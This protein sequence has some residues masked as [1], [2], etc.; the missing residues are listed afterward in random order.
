MDLLG[1]CCLWVFFVPERNLCMIYGLVSRNSV[2]LSLQQQWDRFVSIKRYLWLGNQT[3]EKVTSYPIREI[4]DLFVRNCKENMNP[5][6]E[7]TIDK[8][9]S[10]LF[11]CLWS[12][13]LC[14]ELNI[15][16]FFFSS[17]KIQIDAYKERVTLILCYTIS[18]FKLALP[19]KPHVQI[20]LVTCLQRTKWLSKVLSSWEAKS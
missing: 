7:L 9:L 6:A 10:L 4:V 14:N 8:H 20:Q 13:C 18:F 1:F 5:N 3:S 16:F 19:V 15:C 11:F 17:I 2:G 12:S